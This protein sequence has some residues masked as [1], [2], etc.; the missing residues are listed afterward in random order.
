MRWFTKNTGDV[1]ANVKDEAPVLGT[2][3]PET[4]D[5]EGDRQPNQ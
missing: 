1:A 2:Y 4:Q 5:Q 3:I